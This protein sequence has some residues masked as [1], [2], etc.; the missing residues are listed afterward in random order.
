MSNTEEWSPWSAWRRFRLE[1]ETARNYPS[2][3]AL[4]VGQ[5]HRDILLEQLLP[6]LLY[7]KGA[8]ILDDSLS[9]WLSE[10]GHVLK[11]AYRNDFNGRICYIH[12]NSLYENSDELHAIRKKRNS[13]A[14]E[15]GVISNW[16]ELEIDINS[17]EACLVTFGLVVETK[18]LE[19]FAEPSA[20]QK[21]DDPKIA[22][23]RRFSY[24]VKEDGKLALEIAWN[25]N[26][27]NE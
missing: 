20:V 22:F 12:D 5:T 13:Y 2:S 17:I 4:Y 9:V 14:H 24:G 15:P 23:T 11:K 8:C 3:Y 7:I 18:N 21:S 6:T 25:K 27:S 1:T 19:Y 10:N 16:E 26:T